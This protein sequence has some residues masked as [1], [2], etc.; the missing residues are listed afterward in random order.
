L[1]T[2]KNGEDCRIKKR[3]CLPGFFMLQ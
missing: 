3:H 2:D 1:V